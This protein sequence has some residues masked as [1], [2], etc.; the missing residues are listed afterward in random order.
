MLSGMTIVRTVDWEPEITQAEIILH[1]KVLILNNDELIPEVGSF[2]ST[3]Y[4][5]G[6][7][8]GINERKDHE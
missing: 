8:K 3:R 7:S 6:N 4:A 5:A 2:V 1:L